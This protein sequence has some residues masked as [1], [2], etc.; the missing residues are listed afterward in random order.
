[1]VHRDLKIENLLIDKNNNIKLGDFGFSQYYQSSLMSTWCGS[2][3]YSA[4]EL[5]EHKKYIGPKVD[6]WS[7]GIILYVLTSGQLPFNGDDFLKIRKSVLK[8]HYSI[9]NYFSQEIRQL[10][11]GLL[12]I[13]P[14]DRLSIDAIARH[15]WP[16][17]VATSVTRHILDKLL[18]MKSL[19]IITPQLESIVKEV[20]RQASR[21][22]LTKNGKNEEHFSSI[23]RAIKR[24]IIRLFTYN[25]CSSI[26]L[27]S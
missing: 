10:L 13:E 22:H 11:K 26:E 3:Q 6:I 27:M 15:K 7:L 9:P 18:R 17:K 8:C 14:N 4:P 5:F 1:M 23:H 21:Q 25:T 19:D 20:V 16:S 2:P 24:L 12:V